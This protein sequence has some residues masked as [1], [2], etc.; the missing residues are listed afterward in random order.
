[1]AHRRV[2]L[3][4]V[5]ALLLGLAPLLTARAQGIPATPVPGSAPTGVLAEFEI[6]ELPTPHA[7]VWF[8]RMSLEPN[9]SV[10]LGELIGPM[11]LFIESGRLTVT[12]DG[13]ITPGGAQAA[14]APDPEGTTEQVLQTGD[15]VLAGEGVSASAGNATGEPVTFLVLLMYPAE[16]EGEGGDSMEEPVGLSQQGVSVGAAEF[17]PVPATLTLERVVVEPGETMASDTSTSQGRG[18][19][20]MGMELGA[21]ETG[22]AEV[23]FEGRSFQN[24]TWPA[25]M[26]STNPQPTQ[27]PLTATAQ[28]GQGDGYS[29][30]GSTLSWVATGAEALTVLR[31][32]VT[33]HMP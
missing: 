29:A 20:W 23:V 27:V 6:D 14:D 26:T 2:T 9:G 10:P 13:P 1:M 28:L 32:V 11:L 24:L 21:I 5:G 16:R 30:F 7:E 4:V 31:I 22:S 8:I 12:A 18:P 33:P 25:M 19:G 17:L 3:L 15:S